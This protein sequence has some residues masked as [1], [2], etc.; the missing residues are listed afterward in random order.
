DIVARIDAFQ[1]DRDEPD[2]LPA[3]DVALELDEAQAEHFSFET[4]ARG[5]VRWVAG[6][7]RA[8]LI[9]MPLDGTQSLGAQVDGSATGAF[10]RRAGF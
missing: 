8:A 1:R 10:R 5:V 4:D 6:V 9:G 2:G 7:A 3:N